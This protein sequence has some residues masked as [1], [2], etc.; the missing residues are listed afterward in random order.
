MLI[1]SQPSSAASF[2]VEKASSPIALD[3]LQRGLLDPLPRQGFALLPGAPIR[4][5]VTSL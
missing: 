5:I 1:A 4:A 2:R 3:Q